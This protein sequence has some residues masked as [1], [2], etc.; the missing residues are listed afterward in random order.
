MQPCE[1]TGRVHKADEPMDATSLICALAPR[2]SLFFKIALETHAGCAG[3]QRCVE[4]A[5]A[6][7]KQ[8]HALFGGASQAAPEMNSI[9]DAPARTSFRCN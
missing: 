9:C 4:L 5:Y 7:R 2:R 8:I 6:R 1:E 3:V